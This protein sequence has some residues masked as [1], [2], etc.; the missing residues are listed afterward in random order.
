MV[1]NR[2]Q[3]G[4][5]GRCQK[6]P[7]GCECECHSQATKELTKRLARDMGFAVRFVPLL[8]KLKNAEQ[9]NEGVRL[10]K[11]EVVTLLT[12]L[13]SLTQKPNER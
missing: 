4:Q 9:N 13:R 10:S 8:V 1:S 5:H 2:C 6:R 12:T 7:Y 11:K 3:Q